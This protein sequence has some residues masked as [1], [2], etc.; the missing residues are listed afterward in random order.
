MSKCGTVFDKASVLK[1]QVLHSLQVNR[2]KKSQMSLII[3]FEISLYHLKLIID[4]IFNSK[5][6][7]H[8]VGY[9]VPLQHGKYRMYCGS[10]KIFKQNIHQ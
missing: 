2:I 6:N 1:F 10:T 3:F 8:Q 9:N 7:K 4:Y 5:I